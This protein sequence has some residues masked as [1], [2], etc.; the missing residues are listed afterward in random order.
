MVKIYK[1]CLT[2]ELSLSDTQAWH[3][4][5]STELEKKIGVGF[6]NHLFK[7]EKGMVTLYYDTKE[8]NKFEQALDNVLDEKFFDKLCDEFLELIQTNPTTDKEIQDLQIK[9]WPALT[10]FDEI[11][12]Y[13]E[14]ATES[15]LRR[16]IRIRQN[17]EAFTYDLA[18]KATL[19]NTPKDYIYH[20]GQLIQ[21]PF[22]QFIK[23]NQIVIN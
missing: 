14:W 17:T 21:K 11:S 22:D 2:R 13:P 8:A 4:G 6:Y 9:I 7:S 19:Q 15:M 12:K 23:E 18:K 20:K 5:E 3:K 10:I 16:L 1:K